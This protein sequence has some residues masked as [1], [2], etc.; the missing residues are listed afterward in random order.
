[1]S[2]PRTAQVVEQDGLCPASAPCPQRRKSKGGDQ[3]VEQELVLAEALVAGDQRPRP[4]GLSIHGER[5][6]ADDAVAILLD[7]RE[8]T[9]GL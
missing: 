5:H 6:R 9:R 2:S 8:V 3:L 4:P 1:M 7:V